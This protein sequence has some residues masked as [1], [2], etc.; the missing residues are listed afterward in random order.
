MLLTQDQLNELEGI[1]NLSVGN[2][3]REVEKLLKSLKSTISF[4]NFN[5]ALECFYRWTANYGEKKTIYSGYCY[6]TLNELPITVLIYFF[7]KND[8]YLG[9]YKK[10][11]HKNRD[12][13]YHGGNCY[14][15]DNLYMAVDPSNAIIK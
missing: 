14:F 11:K 6:K 13:I 9:F 7:T 4:I 1:W 2:K 5:S 8:K 15:I 3:D 12:Y 10:S